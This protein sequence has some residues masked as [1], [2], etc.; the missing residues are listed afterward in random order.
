VHSPAAALA[1]DTYSAH[2]V[3]GSQFDDSEADDSQSDDSEADDS[4]TGS[5]ALDGS[6]DGCRSAAPP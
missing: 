1:N 6:A 4:G 5:L 3:A 2:F